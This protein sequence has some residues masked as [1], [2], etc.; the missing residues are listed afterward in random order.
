MLTL[1]RQ[2]SEALRLTPAQFAELCAANPEAVLELAADGRLIEM[3]PAGGETGRRNNQLAVQLGLWA[4]VQPGWCVFDSYTG[5][6]L[7][8]GSVLSPD[9]SAVLLERWQALSSEARQ[10]FPPLCPDLVVE[11]ASPSDRLPDLRR[12]MATYQANGARLGWLLL[13]ESRGV[14]VWHASG[15]PQRLEGLAVLDGEPELPGLRL[16]LAE[17]WDV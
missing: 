11:L 4:R 10:G 15:E 5:F 16:D 17:L 12:K 3:T 1:P 9:A 8:D 7:P 13:P 6:L 14:E 2:L